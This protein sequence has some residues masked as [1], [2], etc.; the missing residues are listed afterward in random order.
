MDMRKIGQLHV[1]VV[2]L[3]CNNFGGRL[4]EAATRRVVDAAL[5]HGIN[6]FDTADM[7]G[8]TESEAFLG[9]ILAGRR[10]QVLLATKF[11]IALGPDRPGGAHPDYLRRA[12]AESLKRL[13]MDHVDLYQLHRPDPKV[14]IADTL[15]ALGELV[16]AGMIREIGCSNFDAAQLAEAHAAVAAGAPR[17][18]SVQN[19]YSLMHREPERGVLSA[20]SRLNVAF[21][22]YFPLMSGLLSGKY[23]RGKP[24]PSGTRVTGNARW[25]SLLTDANYALIEALADFAEARGYALVDLA[26]AW[27]LSKPQVASVIAGATSPEQIASNAAT[28]RWRLSAE[29][30]NAV[31][32]ILTEYPS[33]PRSA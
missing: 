13:R 19:E 16:Q 11:G 29:E 15:G 31:E 33:T 20:C 4:D 5:A 14:P 17:F 26:F 2:G 12:L 8:G 18:V 6:F 10:D 1:S 25:E 9:R 28:A 7:Y 23:R 3:G 21:L 24:L 22:P 27:L 32:A 30:A